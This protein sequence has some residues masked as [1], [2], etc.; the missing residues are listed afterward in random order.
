MVWL[1][2]PIAIAVAA[3]VTGWF[4]LAMAETL[5]G[6][7]VGRELVRTVTGPPDEHRFLRSDVREMDEAF[8]RVVRSY[9]A[10]S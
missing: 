5:Y 2:V 1:V 6:Y 8:R 10:T 4:L 9:L 3:G 7:P